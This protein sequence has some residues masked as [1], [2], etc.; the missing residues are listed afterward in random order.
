MSNSNEHELPF[1]TAKQLITAI[2][3]SFVVPIFTIV[4]LVKYVNQNQKTGAGSSAMTAEATAERIKPV[5]KV[6]LK[7]MNAPKVLKSGEEIYTAACAACHNAGAAGAPKF[8][9]KSAWAP[10]LKQGYDTL[11]QHAVN[12][13]RGMPARGGNPDLDEIEVARAVAHMSNSAG[14]SFKAP[15]PKAAPAAE[16]K[17]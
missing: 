1:K 8:G 13:I 6:E 7:D 11:V 5:A 3:L 9:D 4:L 15:E 14:A 17:K 16:E 12:G 10:R 2:V